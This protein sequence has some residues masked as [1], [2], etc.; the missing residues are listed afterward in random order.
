MVCFSNGSL[1]KQAGSVKCA[2]RVLQV[3]PYV[4][5]AMFWILRG[6]TYMA[7]FYAP[8]ALKPMR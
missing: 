7:R 1:V 4:R 6:Q 3:D 8:L 2:V 5:A